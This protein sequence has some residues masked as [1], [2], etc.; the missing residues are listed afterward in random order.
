VHRTK[1]YRELEAGSYVEIGIDPLK[2]DVTK[3]FNIHDVYKQ[4]TSDS[5]ETS[6][7]KNDEKNAIS[8]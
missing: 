2:I 6:I 3:S 7:Y 1:R 5:L 4:R 8:A